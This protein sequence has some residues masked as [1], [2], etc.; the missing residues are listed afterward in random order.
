MTSRSLA[1]SP[2]E[3]SRNSAL[4]SARSASALMSTL[5]SITSG[6]SSSPDVPEPA[7]RIRM[8]SLRATAYSHD[9]RGVAYLS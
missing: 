4:N 2:S 9:H 5:W 8:H 7:R 3:A 6:A 1:F